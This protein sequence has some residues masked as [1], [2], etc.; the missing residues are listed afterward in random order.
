M[1][2]IGHELGPVVAFLVQHTLK[3]TPRPRW[4]A[5]AAAAGV[6]WHSY[7]PETLLGAAKADAAECSGGTVVTHPGTSHFR[8]HRRVFDE[9]F[10]FSKL[11]MAPS[12]RGPHNLP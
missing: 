10:R 5:R 2:Q 11:C 6:F 9:N 4:L 3:P 8:Q 1:P 7:T 12:L